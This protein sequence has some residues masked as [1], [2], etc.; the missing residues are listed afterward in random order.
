MPA[1]K[2]KSKLLTIDPLDL[3]LVEERSRFFHH[4]RSVGV[5]HDELGVCNHRYWSDCHDH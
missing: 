5:E 2:G 4:K 1:R 3:I